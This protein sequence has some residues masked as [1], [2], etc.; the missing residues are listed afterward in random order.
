MSNTHSFD[1]LSHGANDVPTSLF[2]YG[3]FICQYKLYPDTSMA[4]RSQA[5]RSSVLAPSPM[6]GSVYGHPDPVPLGQSVLSVRMYGGGTKDNSAIGSSSISQQAHTIPISSDG[7]QLHR[8]SDYVVGYLEPTSHAH[9]SIEADTRALTSQ[10]PDRQFVSNP[11]RVG[12]DAQ[13][14]MP[15][16]APRIAPTSKALCGLLSTS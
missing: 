12:V 2:G 16:T 14:W 6:H 3:L 11:Q 8:S 9:Q 13:S 10:L 5:D 7:V 15:P 1:H 4:S